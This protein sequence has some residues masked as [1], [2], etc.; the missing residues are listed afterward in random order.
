M[1]THKPQQV[2]E[3]LLNQNV[4]MSDRCC[5]EA[6][7][8]AVSRPDV[9]TQVRYRKQEEVQRNILSILW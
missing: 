8:L 2:V 3:Q 9:S 1:K 5:R 6:V 4:C 7:T